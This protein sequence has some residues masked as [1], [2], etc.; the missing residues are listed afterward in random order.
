MT[1][2]NSSL[3]GNVLAFK[4]ERHGTELA[5]ERCQAGTRI[6]LESYDNLGMREQGIAFW[7][8]PEQSEELAQWLRP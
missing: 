3:D 1:D 5:F 8:T 7:I 6:V 4:N 2:A